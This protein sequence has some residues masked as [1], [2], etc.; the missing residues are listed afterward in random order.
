MLRSGLGGVSFGVERG[1]LEADYPFGGDSVAVDLGGG[2]VP[3]MRGLQG[4]VGKIAAG[5]GGEELSGGN[6]AG[7]IDME[8]D[9]NVDGAA[10]GGARS[11]RNVWHDL[12]E[13]FALGDRAVG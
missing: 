4:L 2:E 10:D 5:T 6:V 9:G 3:A 8:L 7:G 13:H 1:E 12:I 11:R